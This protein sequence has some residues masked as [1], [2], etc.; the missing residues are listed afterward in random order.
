MAA[1]ET[2]HHWQTNAIIYIYRG[3]QGR[4][5]IVLSMHTPTEHQCLITVQAQKVIHEYVYY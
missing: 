5:I 4:V 1:K 2:I 3:F